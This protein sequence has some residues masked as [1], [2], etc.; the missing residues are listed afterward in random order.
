MQCTYRWRVTN[1]KKKSTKRPRL[2]CWAPW[3]PWQQR[4]RCGVSSLFVGGIKSPSLI[5]WC[6]E[7][8]L[9]MSKFQNNHNPNPNKPYLFC[10][11]NGRLIQN[12]G[13]GRHSD[14]MLA[15]S[16]TNSILSWKYPFFIDFCFR[17]HMLIVGRYQK[18][19][20]VHN[21][22]FF[23]HFNEL[24]LILCI[25]IK[26]PPPVLLTHDHEIISFLLM[27]HD[28]KQCLLCCF[29]VRAK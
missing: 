29:V 19:Y 28:R 22:I 14:K 9:G 6:T 16:A 23:H 18:G 15:E 25:W 24:K 17:F 5:H 4:I 3:A 20:P 11:K 27:S 26:T 7:N 1:T 21:E 2:N 13:L 12:R 8:G 10:R